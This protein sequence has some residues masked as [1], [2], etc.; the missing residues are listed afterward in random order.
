[1]NCGHG[2]MCFRC[3]LVLARKVGK[4]IC[5]IC[6]SQIT[7]VLKIDASATKTTENGE[8]LLIAKE[9]MRVNV[10]VAKKPVKNEPTNNDDDE[11]S[12][13][14]NSNVAS[15]DNSITTF[16]ND[17]EDDDDD[18]SHT[19]SSINAGSLNTRL[20]LEEEEKTNE[21]SQQYQQEDT[22]PGENIQQQ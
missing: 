5:P 3:G 22:A 18:N 1:M 21:V 19:S 20:T 16:N 13:I 6:R 7:E 14:S 2:G 8:L 12:T 4:K 15:D 11:V 10:K 9:G 17:D